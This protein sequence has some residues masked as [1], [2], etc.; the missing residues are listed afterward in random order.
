MKLRL[1]FF[2]LLSINNVAFAQIILT[3]NIGTTLIKTT[4]NTCSNGGIEWS[5]TFVLNDFGIAT[6]EEFTITQGQ[7]GFSRV[8]VYDVNIRFN[9]YKIDDN[10]PNS[11]SRNNLIGSSEIIRILQSSFQLVTLEFTEPVVVPSSIERIL[12]EVRQEFSNSSAVTFIAGTEQDNDFSWFNTPNNGCAPKS[13]TNTIDFGHPDAR[14]FINVTGTKS[15]VLGLDS[16][17]K[18]SFFIFPN[19]V[20]KTL[21]IE[22]DSTVDEI[23]IFNLQ[24]VLMNLKISATN[25]IDVSKLTSGIYFAHIMVNNRV[26]IQKFIKQ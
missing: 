20:T 12:V 13:Y 23:K 11:F 5:R 21:H 3:H 1:L 24:G 16:K 22:H 26:G 7:V 25:S 8:G 15:E 14:F 18:S 17:K 2:I 19:P 4:M 6:N 10:F 9:I